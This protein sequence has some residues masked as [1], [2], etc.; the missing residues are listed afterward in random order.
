MRVREFLEYKGSKGSEYARLVEWLREEKFALSA[1][2]ALDMF[3]RKGEFRTI[4]YANHVSTL[5]AWEIV[6]DFAEAF[7][8]NFPFASVRVKDSIEGIKCAGV[9]GRVWDMIVADHPGG[10]F[11]P[12]DK[13]CEHFDFLGNTLRCLTTENESV[14]VFNVRER[15]LFNRFSIARRRWDFYDDYSPSFRKSLED[16]IVFYQKFFESRGMIIRE[17]RYFLQC[18][19]DYWI[20]AYIFD[21][22]RRN[23]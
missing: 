22:G 7:R 1:A 18:N 20:A 11:G 3:A 6:P 14:L 21:K 9:S 2:R 4:D 12:E 16:L 23:V 17:Y 5:E 19:G 8:E 15:P 10:F 13:Y